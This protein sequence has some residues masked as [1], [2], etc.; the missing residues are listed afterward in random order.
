MEADC[1]IAMETVK[2]NISLPEKEKLRRV[3]EAKRGT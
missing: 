2:D 3:K 1:G